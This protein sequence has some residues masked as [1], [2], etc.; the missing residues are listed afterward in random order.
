MEIRNLTKEELDSLIE[1]APE[2]ETEFLR[3]M[4]DN[5]EISPYEFINTYALEQSGIINGRP[6]Y[7]GA[8]I[9]NHLWTI[10]N[11]DVKEQFTLFKV[12][13]R[14]AQEWAGKH[15]R[16]YACMHKNNEKNLEWTKRLGF[17]F[18]K[19]DN[20]TVTLEMIGGDYGM[21]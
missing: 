16:I 13:K 19:E 5:R 10:V 8:L 7:L 6:I 2:A 12:A 11:K 14:K 3:E 17:K 20:D 18:V 21:R 9:G 15:K 4:T 1:T